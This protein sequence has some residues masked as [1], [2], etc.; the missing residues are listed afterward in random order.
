MGDPKLGESIF[1]T[2]TAENTMKAKKLRRLYFE[3]QEKI[4]QFFIDARRN[5]VENSYSDTYFGRRRYFDRRVKDKG[6]IERE[7]GNNRIQGT[8]ADIYKIAMVRLFTEIRKRG[9]LGKV[10]IPAF[11][12]DEGVL[13]IHKSIDP[14]IMLKIL[15]ECL[16]LKIPGWCPLYIGVGF[17]TNWYDAK[18]TEIPVQVQDTIEETWGD[19]GLD[20]WDGDTEKLFYWE[21]GMINDYKRDRVL[22]FLSNKEN[23]GK[24][25]PPVEN[26]FAHEI[27]EEIEKGRHVEGVVD[28]NTSPKKDTIDNLEEFC[29]VFGKEDLFIKANIQKPA[30]KED[31]SSSNVFDNSS[32]EED[33]VSSM[34]II[35]MKV[36]QLGIGLDTDN[37]KVYFRYDDNDIPLMKLIHDIM[38]KYPGNFEVFAVKDNGE[39]YSTG[40]NLD[41][42]AY[43]SILSAYI[44]RRNKVRSVL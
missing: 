17:G 23:W 37:R 12:H 21:V 35:M 11:V 34:D 13:E 26:A 9:W 20:W 6:S 7:A 16:M 31:E 10:L 30:Y 18:K 42:K 44:S 28:K 5:G 19:T 43:S 39:I 2:R 3:G 41:L 4:E 29:R 1:G 36:R 8:A 33:I 14:A 40:L 25:L 27:L 24:V 32:D 15:R 22:E 38:I